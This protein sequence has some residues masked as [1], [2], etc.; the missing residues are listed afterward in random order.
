MSLA[1]VLVIVATTLVTA[2]L[3]SIFGMLGGVI[4]IALLV[5]VLPVTSAFI[6][7]GLIQLASNGYRAFLNRRDIDWRMI[8]E[9]SVGA[10]TAFLLML[11]I[12]WQPD[13][14]LVMF[15]LGALPFV[16]AAIPKNLALDIT[17]RRMP[18]FAG[19]VVVLTSMITGVGGPLLDVFFQRTG[20]ERHRVIAGKAVTQSI[21]HIAKIIYFSFIAY[22]ISAHET[23]GS[24]L[25]A[26]G[27]EFGL[28]IAFCLL[29]TLIGTII[30]KRVLDT[31]NDAIFYR[32]TGGIMLTLG[33]LLMARAVFAWAS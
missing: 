32:W 22:S 24:A 4:L 19:L 18:L 1:L 29:T 3:S 20:M 28:L 9:F 17:R 31:M 11:A 23:M 13:K 6:L 14:L 16:A 8:G 25:L 10:A 27:F 15:M 2:F 33:A 7:H 5:N 30:G 12:S 26:F 21:G